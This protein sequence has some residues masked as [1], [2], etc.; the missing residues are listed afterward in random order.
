M[1]PSVLGGSSTSGEAKAIPL[2]LPFSA[3]QSRALTFY[4]RHGSSRKASTAPSPQTLGPWPSRVT[5]RVPT[6][7][8][9]LLRFIPTPMHSTRSSRPRGVDSAGSWCLGTLPVPRGKGVAPVWCVVW[10]AV[11]LKIQL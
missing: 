1:P 6:S 8:G 7:S 2:R 9:A 3:R 4:R 10:G 5:A 11:C